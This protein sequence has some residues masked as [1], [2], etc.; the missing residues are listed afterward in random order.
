MLPSA[1]LRQSYQTYIT[2]SHGYAGLWCV[3]AFF[4]TCVA[5]PRRLC[6]SEP[7]HLPPCASAAKLGA[8]FWW[9]DLYQWWWMAEGIFIS[10]INFAGMTVRK[11]KSWLPGQEVWVKESLGGLGEVTF[12]VPKPRALAAPACPRVGSGHAAKLAGLGKPH[13]CWQAGKR[14]TDGPEAI[15]FVKEKLRQ[16]QPILLTGRISFPSVGCLGKKRKT[17]WLWPLFC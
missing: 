4:S 2:W 5:E 7:G 13:L 11:I 9:Q 10:L 17:G 14:N 3:Q 15:A 12:A 6:K 1:E 8:Q 16:E